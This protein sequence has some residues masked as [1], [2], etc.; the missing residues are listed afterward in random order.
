[1]TG[2]GKIGGIKRTEGKKRGIREKRSEMAEGKVEEEDD[3]EHI[4]VVC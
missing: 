3:G 4:Q 2:G 1:M